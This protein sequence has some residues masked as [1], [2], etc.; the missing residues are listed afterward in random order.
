MGIK[1]SLGINALHLQFI[2]E[3]IYQLFF[4]QFQSTKHL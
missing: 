3:K 1:L 4:P 2:Q